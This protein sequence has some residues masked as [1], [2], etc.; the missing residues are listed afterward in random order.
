MGTS[1]LKEIHVSGSLYE[2]YKD[3]LIPAS[4]SFDDFAKTHKAFQDRVIR[5][6]MMGM[7][8]MPAVTYHL[9][10]TMKTPSIRGGFGLGFCTFFV[11]FVMPSRPSA[12]EMAF[13]RKEGPKYLHILI[14]KDPRAE[15]LY[16]EILGSVPAEANFA[17]SNPIS[18]PK[19][20]FSEY[21]EP[22]GKQEEQ[23]WEQRTPAERN[24][25]DGDR[26]DRAES[27]YL[28]PDKSER[29]YV[30]GS[31]SAPREGKDARD[32]PGF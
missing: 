21:S 27:P 30:Y 22:R 19:I 31:L 6:G 12:E 1:G 14:Q 11:L 4:P 25:R 13:V 16:R 28:S 24:W 10:R 15:P 7:L 9:Y 20:S 3:Q 29:P 32:R 17:D 2:A 18:S 5:T 8:L 26:K 23:A